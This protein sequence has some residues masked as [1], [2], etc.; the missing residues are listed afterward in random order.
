MTPEQLKA[1]LEDLI[2]TLQALDRLLPNKVDEELI[3]FLQS[4]T[5]H[6]WLLGLLLKALELSKAAKR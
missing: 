3:S 1:N 2:T 5:Q 4:V 6:D